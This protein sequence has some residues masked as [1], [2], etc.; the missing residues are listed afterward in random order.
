MNY[1]EQMLKAMQGG[2]YIEPPRGK[3]NVKIVEASAFTYNKDNEDR[4][5]ASTVLEILDGE[6]A[7]QSMRHFMGL[8]HPVGKEISANALAAYGINWSEIPSFDDLKVAMSGLVNRSAEVGVSYK[9]GFMNISVSGSR[10][11]VE[12]RQSDIPANGSGFD[13]TPE[14]DAQAK[15]AAARFGDTPDF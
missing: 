13:R 15:A 9:D 10:A 8:H 14:Q 4:D 6:F 3:Y 5:A 11:P 12:D 7:G 2:D 1:G